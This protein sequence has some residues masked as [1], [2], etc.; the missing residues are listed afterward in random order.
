MIGDMGGADPESAGCTDMERSAIQEIGNVMTSGFIDGWANVLQTRIDISTP[1]FTFGPGSGMVDRLVGDPDGRI[2][3][4]YRSPSAPTRGPLPSIRVPFDGTTTET[5]ARIVGR[6]TARR[7]RSAGE[8]D[9]ISSHEGHIRPAE[10][11][12]DR[13]RRR[14]RF[15]LCL[16]LP[17]H[18]AR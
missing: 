9:D 17:R 2:A 8:W 12:P 4:E 15:P 14:G 7:A 3:R 18:T 16:S 13:G 1:E 11:V 10:I 5:V 6:P